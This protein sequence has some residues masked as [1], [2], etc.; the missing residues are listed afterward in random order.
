MKKNI[1]MLLA[2][3]AFNLNTLLAQKYNNSEL[4][5]YVYN[6]IKFST[7]PDKKTNFEVGFVGNTALEAELKSLIAKK[8]NSSINISIKNIKST[9]SKSVD[10]VILANASSSEMKAINALVETAPV[11][12]ITEKKDLGRMGACI[13][14]FID[15]DD[16]FKT[17]YQLSTR[18][19]KAKGIT[20]SEQI[21]NNAVLVR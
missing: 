21:V 6:F 18:N 9:E 3:F 12:V 16:E 4:A 15:E 11:L 8:K 7:W 14:F 17:K 5:T 20:V 13:S 2:I 10:V 19:C 1:I